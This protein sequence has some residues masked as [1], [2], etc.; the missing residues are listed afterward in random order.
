MLVGRKQ[1]VL[2]KIVIPRTQA[3][4]KYIILELEEMA[5]EELFRIKKI[6]QAKL[7]RKEKLKQLK[8]V[9][10]SGVCSIAMKAIEDKFPKPKVVEVVSEPQPTKELEPPKV[11]E[12]EQPKRTVGIKPEYALVTPQEPLRILLQPEMKLRYKSEDEVYASLS[13]ESTGSKAI[14]ERVPCGACEARDDGKIDYLK[15]Q[16]SEVI[17]QSKLFMERQLSKLDLS[18][19]LRSCEDLRHR[20]QQFFKIQ[21]EA[22]DIIESNL[23][24]LNTR[25]RDVVQESQKLKERGVDLSASL[26]DF[27]KTCEETEIKINTYVRNQEPVELSKKRIQE[28]K[29]LISEIESL[30]KEYRGQSQT[31]SAVQEFLESCKNIKMRIDSYNV[32][33][34]K[35]EEVLQRKDIDYLSEQLSNVQVLAEMKTEGMSS[36]SVDIFVTACKDFKKKLAEYI[37]Q[38]KELSSGQSVNKLIGQINEAISLSKEAKTKGYVSESVEDFIKSCENIK[39][40]LQEKDKERKKKATKKIQPP[41]LKELKNN[42]TDVIDLVSKLRVEGFT[43]ESVENFV[44]SCETAKDKIVLSE[45]FPL[46]EDDEPESIIYP[47]CGKSCTCEIRENP[48]AD[49][50]TCLKCEDIMNNNDEEKISSVRKLLPICNTCSG[51]SDKESVQEPTQQLPR[52]EGPG[53]Q[54]PELKCRIEEPPPDPDPPLGLFEKKIKQIVKITRTRNKDG[55]VREE[56]EI[57]TIKEESHNPNETNLHD[58]DLR[59]GTSN[60]TLMGQGSNKTIGLC[61]VPDLSRGFMPPFRNV[62]SEIILRTGLTQP[63]LTA[64]IRKSS[65]M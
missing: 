5:R 15:K 19:F 4:I 14:S 25:I 27:L 51:I 54:E 41:I 43:S 33:K 37:E 10:V 9:K 47:I 60:G 2:G 61:V 29:D 58:V 21:T 22:D 55:T 44:K 13:K 39:R 28:W 42:I 53:F 48:I 16:I 63:L 11:I 40:R 36:T 56:K 65:I 38:N 52:T 1:N 59:S 20:M 31:T 17:S 64:K 23:D 7:K 34:P 6:V 12:P 49:S 45:R 24:N 32:A 50:V 26:E 8:T 46:S 3:T 62:R 57:I 35:T 30:T 18:I